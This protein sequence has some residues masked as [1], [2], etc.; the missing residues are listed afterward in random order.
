M[1]TGTIAL[2]YTR[3][4]TRDVCCDVL[5][6]STDP[7]PPAQPAPP[8][9]LPWVSVA[10][11]DVRRWI[12]TCHYDLYT[13]DLVGL[14]RLSEECLAIRMVTPFGAVAIATWRYRTQAA[15]VMG[16]AFL[17][18]SEATS[19]SDQVQ[20]N[21]RYE[22]QHVVPICALTPELFVAHTGIKDMFTG[23]NVMN[24]SLRPVDEMIMVSPR[25]IAVAYFDPKAVL[26]S[27]RLLG[28]TCAMDGG[29]TT[30]DLRD[31]NTFVAGF[32]A[33]LGSPIKIHGRIDRMMMLN[34]TTL[35]C[36][37]EAPE[38]YVLIN[39]A[40]FNI[41]V[42][43]EPIG[44]EVTYGSNFIW[45]VLPVDEKRY[46]VVVSVRSGSYPMVGVVMHPP[47]IMLLDIPETI[48]SPAAV[49]HVASW[50]VPLPTPTFVFTPISRFLVIGARKLL[51]LF[52]NGST[53]TTELEAPPAAAGEP[54]SP[55]APAPSR[56]LGQHRL[57]VGSM[58]SAPASFA[59]FPW[60]KAVPIGSLGFA[61]VRKNLQRNIAAMGTYATCGRLGLP[62]HL[63]EHI[64]GYL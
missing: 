63:L 6:I 54:T 58:A 17:N 11:L 41:I 1:G 32:S 34:S 31:M 18:S 37:T 38:S 29:R 24:H 3:A 50:A 7:A 59:S 4:N 14:T 10:S 35:C 9:H 39:T 55:A 36:K 51:I 8:A 5:K 46:A 30:S 13:A 60:R 20:R 57:K 56:I 21:G 61:V 64:K 2:L 44:R 19:V 62:R 49:D 23:A 48:M 33:A 43:R 26:T 15:P 45:D 27:I 42:A 52:A 16:E 12:T 40:T 28:L 53:I 22:T 25:H 47:R